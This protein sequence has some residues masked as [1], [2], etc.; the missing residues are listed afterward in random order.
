VDRQRGAAVVLTPLASM[1]GVGSVRVGVER[2]DL[3]SWRSRN[4]ETQAA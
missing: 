4:H 1:E 3:E 2:W